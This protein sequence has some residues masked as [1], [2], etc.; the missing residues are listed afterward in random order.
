MITLKSHQPE[1]RCASMSDVAVAPN[2]FSTMRAI[3]KSIAIPAIAQCALINRTILRG[4]QVF[5]NLIHEWLTRNTLLL[6]HEGFVGPELTAAVNA[7]MQD[8]LTFFEMKDR[9]KIDAKLKTLKVP[10]NVRPSV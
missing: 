1:D 5:E 6:K 4:E 9:A 7:L 10:Q 8:A 2:K 3:P